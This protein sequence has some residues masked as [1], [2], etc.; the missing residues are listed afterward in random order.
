MVAHPTLN[1]LE[2]QRP[3]EEYVFTKEY[4]LNREC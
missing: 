2:V 1:D 3:S 4:G